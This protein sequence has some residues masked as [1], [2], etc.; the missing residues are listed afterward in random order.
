MKKITALIV[1]ALG[2]ALARPVLAEDDQ[3][4]GNYWLR[5]CKK[6]PKQLAQS[7]GSFQYGWCFGVVYGLSIHPLICVPTQVPVVQEMDVVMKYLDAHPE[8]RHKSFRLLA[9]EALKE[10]FPLRC[11]GEKQMRMSCRLARR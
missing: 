7:S 10:A 11:W 8:T 4:S 3:T 1:L 9:L 5:E 2:V 6:D